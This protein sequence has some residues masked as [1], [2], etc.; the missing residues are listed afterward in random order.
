[1]WDVLADLLMGLAAILLGALL[2]AY[3]GPLAHHL[4]EGDE[5]YRERF[6]WVQGVEPRQGLLATDRGRWWLLRGWMLVTALGYAAVGVLLALR[7]LGR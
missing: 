5:R 3:S 1:M 2:A 7:A 4:K 6:R